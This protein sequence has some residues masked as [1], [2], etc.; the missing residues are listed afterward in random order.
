MSFRPE[1]ESLNFQ[2]H[3]IIK[4][5]KTV[6]VLS[7]SFT[8]FLIPG[9]PSLDTLVAYTGTYRVE[10]DKWITSVE[11]A[12]NPAW[13]GTE[14]SQSFKVEGD[15]LQVLTPWLG[16]AQLGRQ[17]N[18]PEHYDV[19]TGE[20]EIG[21]DPKDKGTANSLFELIVTIDH[22][23]QEQFFNEGD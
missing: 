2:I 18:D 22:F 20:I 23:L 12:W 16:Y 17:G 10:G 21:S 6:N 9:R 5:K 1:A 8:L 13:V 4:N 3:F 11:V 15:R 14:Q 7:F 19:Q